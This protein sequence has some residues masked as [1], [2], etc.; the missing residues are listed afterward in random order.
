MAIVGIAKPIGQGRIAEEGEN[1]FKRFTRTYIVQTNSATD[2]PNT[3]LS[4]PGLPVLADP[5]DGHPTAICIS[6]N[7]QPIAN[8]RLAWHVEVEWSTHSV[9]RDENPLNTKPEI[10]FGFEAIEE[11]IPG[12]LK[13]GIDPLGADPNVASDAD[14]KPITGP[15]AW[16]SEGV[17][18]SAGDPYDPPATRPN[19]YPVIRYARN[20]ASFTARDAILYGNTTNLTT[21]NGLYPRQVWLKP[22]EATNAVQYAA[23]IDQPDIL[24]WRVRYTFVLKAETWI[25]QLLNIG[26]NYLSLPKTN[27]NTIRFRFLRDGQPVHDLLQNDGTK[28]AKGATKTPTYTRVR[29]LREVDFTPLNININL[30]LTDIRRPAG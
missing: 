21:W 4:A 8:T 28:Y 30:A 18:N 16:W 5:Y 13:A 17:V 3:V 11:P 1:G 26:P 7:P 24:Y 27:P 6:R 19:Y 15:S 25:L 14:G 23:G 2:G 10:E 20:Q 22:I 12:S 29:V 9:D